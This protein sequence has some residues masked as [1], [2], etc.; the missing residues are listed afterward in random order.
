[1][2]NY[3]TFKIHLIVTIVSSAKNNDFLKKIMSVFLFN[4]ISTEW[5]TNVNVSS[6]SRTFL[7]FLI[8][9]MVLG[10]YN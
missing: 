7:L 9:E 4:I 10:I 8:I 3:L 6:D 5:P 1:M 2:S